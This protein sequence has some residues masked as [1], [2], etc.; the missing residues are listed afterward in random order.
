MESTVLID[1]FQRHTI[2]RAAE[3]A[4]IF[5]WTPGT[6]LYIELLVDSGGKPYY[7]RQQWIPQSLYRNPGSY[8]I[9]QHKNS[10]FQGQ[11]F[12]I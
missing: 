9:T 4:C 1:G 5:S 8:N 11:A 10:G 2:T 6:N 3:S 7:N 12:V